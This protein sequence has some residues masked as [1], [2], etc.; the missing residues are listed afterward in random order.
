MLTYRGDKFVRGK[1][2]TINEEKYI[3]SKR[4]NTGNLIFESVKD[5]SKL[6]LTEE[7]YNEL[8]RILT[9]KINQENKEINEIIGKALR[10]KSTARKYE[11]LLKSKGIDI[12]YDTTQGV[13]LK[14]PNG[15]KLSASSKEVYGPATPGHNYTH[16]QPDSWYKNRVED[17]TNYAKE[18]EQALDSLKG[19]KRDDIIRKYPKLSSKEALKKHREEIKNTEKD[20]DYYNSEAKE[21]EDDY[22]KSKQENK[23]FKRAGHQIANNDKTT[24]R[25]QA[26][27]T[28]DYLN[29]LTKTNYD[30]PGEKD[31]WRQSYVAGNDKQ[32]EDE[33]G[34]KS[35][36]FGKNGYPD[37][38]NETLKQ[39]DEL[40]DDI[41]NAKQD[42]EWHTYNS[43]SDYNSSY[44][45][46]TDKQLEAKIKK[47]R[48]ELEKQIEDL[49]KQNDKNKNNQ[50]AE[51]KEL[52][53]REKALDDFLKSK[54]V[55][56]AV[57]SII[58]GNLLNEGEELDNYWGFKDIYGTHPEVS[59]L[60]KITDE[61]Y[62]LADLFK[63]D[64][65]P[66]LGRKA[67]KIAIE[68]SELTEEAE[69]LYL[70]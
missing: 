5:G 45:A 36:Y 29:Y 1:K 63:S 62:G 42:V 24:P 17:Y 70:K 9:E 47:M 53:A 27:Q 25:E 19:L 49:R 22:L 41:K 12:D 14:G 67:E 21:Y 20:I 66:D 69:Q 11:D 8:E 43:D 65:Y 26:D 61:I 30:K 68:L 52:K 2:F 32:S 64:G 35:N 58:N 34:N 33:W 3:F 40:K 48:D 44:A 4:D 60:R 37:K 56:E 38:R 31:Y 55:R 23:R 46:M 59:N 15:Q 39:Y 13:I 16:K 10:S 51:V 54:G 50:S 18:K 28:I 6:N 7:K 57:L